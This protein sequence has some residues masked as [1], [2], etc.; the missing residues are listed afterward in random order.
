MKLSLMM[1][2][3]LCIGDRVAI[4][5]GYPLYNDEFAKTGRYNLSENFFCSRPPNCKGLLSQFFS[6][7][8]D[9][10]YKYT[11]FLLSK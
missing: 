9:Y 10:C 1:L 8:A 6:H 2:L 11:I 4:E 3:L 5:P 7:K